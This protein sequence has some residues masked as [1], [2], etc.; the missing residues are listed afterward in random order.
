MMST[1]GQSGAPIAFSQD[2]IRRAAA[3][4]REHWTGDIVDTYVLANAALRAALRHE[5]DVRGL[6]IATTFTQKKAP[7][8]P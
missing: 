6:G 5:A 4:I 7:E 1:Y 8:T 2:H 3:A